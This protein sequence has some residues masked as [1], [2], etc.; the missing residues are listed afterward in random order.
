MKILHICLA[1]F[2]IDNFSY[3]ENLL[4]KYHK[5]LGYDVSILASLQT[6]DKNG[7]ASYLENGSKYINE[8]GIPVTRIEY[9]KFIKPICRKMKIYNSI[10]ENL[11]KEHPDIIFIHGCQFSNMNDIKKYAIKNKNV[12]IYVDNHCDF[13]NS[14]K[15]WFSKNILHK[16]FWKHSAK[17]IEPYTEKF[18]GVLPAR[19]EFL[20]NIYKINENKVELLIMGADDEKVK[21]ATDLN[22][23]NKI[24]NQYGIKEDDF[25]IVTG[26]KIDLFKKQ[27]ILLM[28]AVKSINNPKIKLIVFGSIVDELQNKV[29]SLIDNKLVQ[30]IGWIN[31]EESYKYFASADLVVFPG[32]HSVFWEQVVALKIPMVVKYWEGSNHI[33]I[34]NNCKFLYDDD[35]DEIKK[36]IYDLATDEEKYKELKKNSED[37]GEN[38]LYGNIA[39]ASLN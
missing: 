23:K 32:R 22:L 2:Y 36:L 5:K 26:G 15:N 33:N 11:V 7:N 24:R 17:L 18:Y 12:I 30:Y 29:K 34:N 39:K 6:F 3:Q 16:V 9:K 4:P 21:E 27:T 8:Y 28:E 1:A 19:V 31:S 20:K 14:A 25:L 10:Y 35:V 13:S 38:F 37:V